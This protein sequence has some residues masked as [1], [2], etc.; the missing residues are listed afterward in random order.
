LHDCNRTKK[1]KSKKHLTQDIFTVLVVY[2]KVF[3][4]ENTMNHNPIIVALDTPLIHEA[5]R[6]VSL[7]KNKVHAFKIGPQLLYRQ[8]LIEGAI[9]I[10]TQG[11]QTFIDMKFHDI[12]K[13]VEES[14]LGIRPLSPSMFTVHALGGVEMLK[15]AVN[16]NNNA[17]LAD[18]NNKPMVL[19]V[20]I[21]TSIDQ[22]I[23][24]DMFNGFSMSRA[25]DNLIDIAADAEVDGVVCS[26][27]EVAKIKQFYPYLKTVVPGIRFEKES[28]DQKRVMTP[29][30]AIAAGADYLVIG[31]PIVQAEDP[32]Q[33]VDQILED[34]KVKV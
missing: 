22:N 14:V 21:L 6:L 17:W 20:T 4:K 28:D 2:A 18:I 25:F 16:A 26:G 34:I 15:A 29:K 30:E 31:R 12:P 1:R 24:W 5:L 13:T 27:H 33:V 32:V 19:A 3:L 23:W 9:R 7:L 8:G 10:R 11:V